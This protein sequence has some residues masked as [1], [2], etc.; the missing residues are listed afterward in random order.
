MK[1]IFILFVVA[2]GVFAFAPGKAEAMGMR[3]CPSITFRNSHHV[4]R[5]PCTRVVQPHYHVVE[6]RWVDPC[7]GHMIVEHVPVQDYEVVHYCPPR[8]VYSR[9]TDFQVKF[10]FR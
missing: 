4:V 6:H 3:V 2:L 1:N 5:G 7:T 9:G 8:R 10:K